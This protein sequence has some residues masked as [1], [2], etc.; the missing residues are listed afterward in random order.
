MSFINQQCDEEVWNEVPKNMRPHLRICRLVNIM[1][2]IK[3]GNRVDG[4]KIAARKDTIFK[5]YRDDVRSM[6]LW[7]NSPILGQD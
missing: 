1:P 2:V 5:D 7:K 6:K 4:D 3:C